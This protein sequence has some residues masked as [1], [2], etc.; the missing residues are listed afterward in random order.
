MKYTK[1]EV[2]E[3]IKEKGFEPLE[4]DWNGYKS[5]INFK[6]KDGYKYSISWSR[7]NRDDCEENNITLICL[8]YDIIR[9][10]KFKTILNDIF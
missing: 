3:R 1:D 8:K 10:G 6:D 2:I 5:M 7:F 9:N 4:F